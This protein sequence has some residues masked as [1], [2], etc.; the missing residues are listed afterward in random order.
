M[1]RSLWTAL[2]LSALVSLAA[3][4]KATAPPKKEGYPLVAP[5]TR[6]SPLVVSDESWQVVEKKDDKWQ[7]SYKF[8]VRNPSTNVVNS[9]AKIM[10][11]DK[12]G[13]AVKMESKL[14]IIEPKQSRPC[15]GSVSINAETAATVQSFK[16]YF[17]F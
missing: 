6:R 17:E 7:F 11:K 10:F 4:K 12:E 1:K 2:I 8:T 9:M 13:Y 14:L 16:A 5:V 3:D 15:T